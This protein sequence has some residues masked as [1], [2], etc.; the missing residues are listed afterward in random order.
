MFEKYIKWARKNY[1]MTE[2]QIKE[3]QTLAQ[4]LGYDDPYAIQDFAADLI[5]NQTPPAEII[6]LMRKGLVKRQL[7]A[8]IQN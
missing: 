1:G 8:E 6:D 7:E 3:F 2:D 4:S 5:H